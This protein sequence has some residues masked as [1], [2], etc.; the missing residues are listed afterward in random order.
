[1]T[2]AALLIGLSVGVVLGAL[3]VGFAV[4]DRM[5][6]ASRD[7]ARLAVLD[8][9]ARALERRAVEAEAR[10]D[11]ERGTLDERVASAVRSASAAAMK[12]S[13]GAFLDLAQTKLDAYVAPLRESLGKV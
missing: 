10:L 6:A 7:A 9:E 8:T 12:E 4:R 3:G 1:M 11:A 5:R 2:I 13:S